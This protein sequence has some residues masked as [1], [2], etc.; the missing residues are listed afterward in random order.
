M[1]RNIVLFVSLLCSVFHCKTVWASPTF[2]ITPASV[3]VDPNGGTVVVSIEDTSLPHGM[4]S[5]YGVV[6]VNQM[7]DTAGYVDH[8]DFQYTHQCFCTSN[9]KTPH[10]QSMGLYLCHVLCQIRLRI[11]MYRAC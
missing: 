6:H 3:V 11:I 2:A 7:H 4:L 9:L 5:P 1:L 10:R 8:I